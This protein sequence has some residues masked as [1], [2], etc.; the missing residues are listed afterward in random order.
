MKR[1]SKFAVIVAKPFVH[2]NHAVR[3]NA[4]KNAKSAAINVL[5]AQL[6]LLAVAK[7]I[8]SIL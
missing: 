3:K 7:H 4:V 8:R 6:V 2:A 1:E 5:H